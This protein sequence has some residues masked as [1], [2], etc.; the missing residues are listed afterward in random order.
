M[1]W[2]KT[3]VYL[4]IVLLLG[5]EGYKLFSYQRA[6]DRVDDLIAEET[7]AETVEETE[8]EPETVESETETAAPDEPEDIFYKYKDLYEVNSDMVGFIYLTDEYKYPVVQRV[9]DQ[10][11]YLHQNF[12]DEYSSGGSIFANAFTNLGEQGISLIY[13][14]TMR[15]GSMFGSLKHYKE[16]E[17]FEEHRVIQLDTLHEEMFYEVV[18]VVETSLHEDFAY[19]DY[20][21]DV[22][23]EDFNEWKDGMSEALLQG[24]LDTIGYGDTIVELSCCAYQARDGRLVLVL[25][26]ISDTL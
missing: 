20:V 16:P 15:N 9:D 8:S 14:H 4:M 17:Y 10:N 24:S 5:I 6:V 18:G 23:E 11:Y 26:R 2:A 19:Y 25:K 22:S 3:F 21:G 13:G 1:K 7:V 12:F